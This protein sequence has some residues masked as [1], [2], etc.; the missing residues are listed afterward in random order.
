MTKLY[1]LLLTLFILTSCT[2]D[3]LFCGTVTGGGFDSYTSTYF[4]RVD[5]KKVWTDEKT[6]DSYFVGDYECFENY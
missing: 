5:G 2:K 1:T 3:E 4:L 6:Y